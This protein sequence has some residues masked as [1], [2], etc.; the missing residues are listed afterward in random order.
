MPPGTIKVARPS[1]HGNP[2]VVGGLVTVSVEGW[3]EL[4]LILD[5]RLAVE[6]FRVEWDLR[7][8][9]IAEDPGL[10]VDYIAEL[11]KLR[12]HDL[13]C[14]CPLDGEP[15]HRDVLLGISNDPEVVALLRWARGELLMDPELD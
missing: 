9:L 4:G 5:R 3:G 7:L 11:E 6:L 2:F 8:D 15:C 14:W 1:K 13:A 10:T 12:G